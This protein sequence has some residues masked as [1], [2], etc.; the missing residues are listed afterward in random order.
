MTRWLEPD[1][2]SAWLG[3]LSSMALLDDALDT[4]LQRDAGITHATFAILARLSEANER[5]LHMSKLSVWTNSSPSRLSHAVQRLER[6]GLVVRS[7][8][9]ANRRAVH[10][11]LTDK[12][13]GVLEAAAPGHVETVRDLVFDQ[14]TRQQVDQLT[15]ITASIL[16]ALDKAG[17][18]V[19]DNLSH[20][21]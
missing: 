13:F 18:F 15:A 11:T 17:H 1:E 20:D 21:G 7:P 8:C 10:A 4:Q 9:P 3:M 2:R 16:Q 5:S 6:D 12:G 14:L 19:P